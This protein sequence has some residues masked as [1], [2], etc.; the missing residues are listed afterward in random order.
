MQIWLSYFIYIYIYILT[1]S[2]F[3]F[4]ITKSILLSLTKLIISKN[5]LL[6]SACP[7]FTQS[8]KGLFYILFNLDP[9]DAHISNLVDMSL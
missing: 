9:G 1:H 2:I 7:H 5:R 8:P 6:L 4:L 3:C